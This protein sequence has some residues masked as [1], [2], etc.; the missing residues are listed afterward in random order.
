M[1]F[2]AYKNKKIVSSVGVAIHGNTATYLV[3]LNIDFN[4]TAND[5]LLWKIIVFL[6]KRK[7]TKFDLGGVD[8]EEN[9]NV[10]TFKS[11]FGG[12]EYNLVGSK[13][14]VL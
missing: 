13:I 10:S 2:N 3:G 8:Y 6:K 5:L 4:Q 7:F 9:K 1:I 14:L 12:K 11:N